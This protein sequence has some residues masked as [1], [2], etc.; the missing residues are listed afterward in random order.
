M[1]ATK[2]TGKDIRIS[3]AF[4]TLLA[5]LISPKVFSNP[6]ITLEILPNLTGGTSEAYGI[7]DAGQVVGRAST[8]RGSN[9]VLWEAGEIVNLGTLGGDTSTAY[10]INS[11]GQIVGD[12]MVGQGTHAFLWDSGGMKDLGAL[13]GS[14]STAQDINDSGHIV[15]YSRVDGKS[16]AFVWMSGEM[17]RFETMDYSGVES[18]EAYAINDYKVVGTL[19]HEGEAKAFNVN[20]DGYR[21]DMGLGGL[22]GNDSIAS[23]INNHSDIVGTSSTGSENH[24]FYLTDFNSNPQKGMVDIGT[25][26]GKNS[27]AKAVNETQ[28]VV[29]ESDTGNGKHAFIWNDSTGISDLAGLTGETFVPQSAEDINN[30]SQIVG[31]GSGEAT[32]GSKQAYVLTLHPDWTGGDGDWDSW[33]WS[34]NWN[35]AGTG[36]A[37]RN[38]KTGSMHEVVINP[39]QSA[40]IRSRGN[41]QAKTVQIGG[42]EGQRVTLAQGGGTLNVTHGTTV[43]NGGILEGYGRIQSDL[44]VLAGGKVRTSDVSDSVTQS[45]ITLELSGDVHNEGKIEA[46][47]HNKVAKLF[48]TGELENSS[49]GQVNLLNAQV[50]LDEGIKNK[51]RLNIA[52]F[53]TIA[54]EIVN[55]EEARISVSG[56]E[57]DVIMWDN[58][59]NNGTVIVT[60]GSTL[61]MFGLTDGSGNFI[62]G[63]TKNFAGG[64]AVGNS[65]G[66]S[67][68]EG[69]VNFS[70]EVLMEIGGTT[71]GTE[72][73]KII[74]SNG[75]VN[76]DPSAALNIF[77]TNEYQ[78]LAGD[79]FDLFDWNGDYSALNGTFGDLLLP[80]LSNGFVWNI[81]D[82]YVDGSIRVAAVPIPAAGWLFFSGLGLM[83]FFSTRRFRME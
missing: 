26:G 28:Q 7:N 1:L 14:F 23:D 2:N 30:Y 17:K 66:E 49:G 52:G 69:S 57:S 11:K 54:G 33:S 75:E 29:G 18:S 68:L 59:H 39:G 44:H 37:S 15:G 65:P 9:A 16:N 79:Y 51:G 56:K 43:E 12:S 27:A 45:D 50:E 76:I 62:G 10:A 19:K 20:I 4:F 13:G 24:A 40:T 63:G 77:W 72:H 64:Y 31:Y 46:L 74:F 67:I 5:M 21:L 71:P 8:R 81:D 61:S 41:N 60:D 32:E 70:G 73:D 48:V 83:G 58:L 42:T 47:A 3:L 35:W 82:L 53:T 38:A 55:Q 25:L 34:S 6:R 80:A 22:G 78:A 36:V